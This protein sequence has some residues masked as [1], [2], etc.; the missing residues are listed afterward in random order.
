MLLYSLLLREWPSKDFG[1]FLD[2]FGVLTSDGMQQNMFKTMATSLFGVE[3][4]EPGEKLW[5]VSPEKRA[6]LSEAN[7]TD[8]KNF[9]LL[10]QKFLSVSCIWTLE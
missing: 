6:I 5:W 3:N 10:N 1:I 4:F 2:Y 8:R 9:M 7:T